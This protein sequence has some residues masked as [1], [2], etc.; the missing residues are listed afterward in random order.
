MGVGKP[1]LYR[2]EYCDIAIRV[3]ANGESLAAVC[4]ELDICRPTLY[5]WKEAHPD[6]SSAINKGLQHA[7]RKWECI[8]N[9]GV[10]G[11]IDKFSPAPWIFTMK[12][13]FREDYQED[14][15]DDKKDTSQSVLE[16]IISGEL[17]VKND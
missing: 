7:Q 17:K 1:T 12:N 9:E 16:K 4:C 11:H 13:R 2:P 5:A 6:F 10:N 8:G 15:K 14:K 3:L